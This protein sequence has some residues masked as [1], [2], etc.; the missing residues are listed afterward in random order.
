MS[1]KYVGIA[2][3]FERVKGEKRN[4]LKCLCDITIAL[5]EREEPFINLRHENLSF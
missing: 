1:Q 4:A 5:E 2:N 3:L